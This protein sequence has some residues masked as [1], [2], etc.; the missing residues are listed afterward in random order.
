MAN[1]YDPMNSILQ[2]TA[3][4]ISVSGWFWTSLNDQQIETK[5]VWASTGE[6]ATFTSW[7]PHE[8]ENRIDYNCVLVSATSGYWYTLGCTSHR[9]VL[10]ETQPVA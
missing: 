2:Y 9:Y 1:I 3:C 8:P 7:G 5:Y 6:E 4:V 10:C